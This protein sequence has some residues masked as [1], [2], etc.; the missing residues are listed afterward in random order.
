MNPFFIGLPAF[1]IFLTIG[2]LFRER[3]LGRLDAM[4]AGTWLL[5]IRRVRLR[6][7]KIAGA[8][9]V[10]VLILRFTLPKLQN[11]WFL[12]FLA[13]LLALIG[14]AQLKSYKIARSQQMPAEFIKLYGASLV[15]DLL[16]YA[17]LCGSMVATPF[18]DVPK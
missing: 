8:A 18:M 15:C 10:T 6:F 12:I 2:Y 14:Y 9:F 3:S 17:F 1:L 16:G 4:Q 13:L 7:L 5:S 11:L